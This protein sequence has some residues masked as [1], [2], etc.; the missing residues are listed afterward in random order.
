MLACAWLSLKFGSIY[1][2]KTWGNGVLVFRK[3]WAHKLGFSKALIYVW[4]RPVD[5]V[6]GFASFFPA[7][8]RPFSTTIFDVTHLL[9]SVFSPSSTV[10]I[11]NYNL[12]N[13]YICNKSL[14]VCI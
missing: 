3:N 5:K 8:Y 6:A 11:T 2:R 1:M 10:P 14:G 13:K 7:F 9:S 12:L 4:Q